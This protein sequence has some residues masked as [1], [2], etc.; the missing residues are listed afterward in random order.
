MMM[1]M[2]MDP[3]AFSDYFKPP[4]AMQAQ[5]DRLP[6]DAISENLSKDF[7]PCLLSLR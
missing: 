1:M 5:H 4:S 6:W 3:Y 7:L 2:N